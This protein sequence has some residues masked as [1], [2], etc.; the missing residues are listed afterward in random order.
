M[1][2]MKF[3]KWN[4]LKPVYKFQWVKKL[5]SYPELTDNAVSAVQIITTTPWTNKNYGL[6]VTLKSVNTGCMQIAC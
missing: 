3:M 5:R 2:G 4:W 1:R 6:G